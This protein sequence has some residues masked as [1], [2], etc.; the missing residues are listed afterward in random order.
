M[1]PITVIKVRF[2]SD[3]FRY[4]SIFGSA[5]SI[6]SQNGLKGLFVGFG[7]TALRD[8]PMAGIY[9]ACY[10]RFKTITRKRLQNE[11]LGNA[12]A[13]VLGGF[14]ATAATQPFDTIKTRMQLKPEQYP[15]ILKCCS[16]I[17]SNEGTRGF[18]RGT[19]ARLLRKSLASAIAW[20][21]YEEMIKKL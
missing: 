9:V 11:T 3:I 8:A 19:V 15:T 21:V 18:Y 17:Y 6:I 16:K 13:G 5:K 20:T 7:A 4:R 1:M 14:I 2:E 10:E 12:I